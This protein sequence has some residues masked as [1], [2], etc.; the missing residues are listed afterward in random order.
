VTDAFASEFARLCRVALGKPELLPAERRVVVAAIARRTGWPEAQAAELP[1]LDARA[2]AGLG[3]SAAELGVFAAHF[4]PARA[5]ELQQA[6]A[7]EVGLDGFARRFGAADGLLLLDTLFA[8]VASDGVVHPVE[9]E[10]LQAAASQL[11]IDALVFAALL[12]THIRR[13]VGVRTFAV[14]ADRIRIGRS[15]SCDLVLPHP[16]VADVHAELVDTGE[17]WRVFARDARPTVVDRLAVSAS[18]LHRGSRIGVGP[19]EVTFQRD[20]LTVSP[21]RDLTALSVRGLTMARDGVTLLDDVHF[22][23][24]TGEVV[25]LV[26]PSGCGKSTLLAAISGVTPADSGDVLLDGEPFHELLAVDPAM[27]GDVPQDDLVLPELSVAESLLYAGLLRF[28]DP[29]SREEVLAEVTRVLAELGIEH[30]RASRIGNALRRGISGGQRK[31]VNLGQELMG[32]SSR[33]LFLDEPTS[34]LD[35]RAAHEIARLARRLAD[36]GRVVFL[37]THDLSP[38]IL[39]QVD[40]LLLLVPGGRVAWFGP[41]DECRAWIGVD[42]ADALFE[43]LDDRTPERWAKRYAESPAHCKYVATREHVV[44]LRGQGRPVGR[45]RRPHRPFL[46]TFRT[47]SARLTRIKLRDHASL[48]VLVLQPL[49]LALVM[50]LVF[51][52]PT[53]PLVFMLTLSCLWFGMS[54]AVRELIVDRVVW[55]RERRIGVGVDAYLA[56]KAGVLG[57]ATVLQCAVLT[58]LVFHVTGLPDGGFSLPALAGV[59][60]LTGLTGM[61]LGLLVS[62]SVASSEAAVGLLVLLLVPQIA[63]SGILM[64]L[65]EMS[66]PARAISS[67]TIQR[68]ALDA[69]LRTGRT[70][71]YQGIASW[72]KRPVSGDLYNLGFRPPGEGSGLGLGGATMALGG[73]TVVQLL[74]TGAVVWRR[75]RAGGRRRIRGESRRS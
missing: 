54:A 63:F 49:V 41:P 67:V 22:T 9:M 42:T 15:P 31:R 62:A 56:S 66:A 65:G 25:A 58:T 53:T 35:P 37:V 44:G 29:V 39:A 11:G 10:R 59:L 61:S 73:F 14:T 48:A 23:V 45:A 5:A 43:R 2:A 64:P 52:R 19:Y 33:V 21:A 72:Q 4:G 34:G 38:Q 55:R 6:S 16:H 47:L 13:D 69:A 68:Y 30:I 74:A 20:H 57:L 12:H 7:A 51:A 3:V 28:P 75:G 26:G 60:S 36:L 46:P 18:P 70:V 27:V 50:A 1:A 71:E 40:H 32:R 8:L 17:G 24:F